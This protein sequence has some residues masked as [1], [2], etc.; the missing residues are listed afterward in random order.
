MVMLYIINL[1]SGAPRFSSIKMA[2]VIAIKEPKPKQNHCLQ[3]WVS[4]W[5]YNMH[6]VFLLWPYHCPAAKNYQTPCRHGFTYPENSE[7]ALHYVEFSF[8]IGIGMVSPNQTQVDQPQTIL[9]TLDHNHALSMLV[10]FVA[11][12]SGLQ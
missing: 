12:K 4:A 2:H 5:A 8:P 1:R 7:V 3:E 6:F 10:E 9:Q 11:L